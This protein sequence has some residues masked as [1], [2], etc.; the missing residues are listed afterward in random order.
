MKVLLF[1]NKQ[2]LP[3]AMKAKQIIDTFGI[4][5]IK[6]YTILVKECSVYSNT[7]LVDGFTWLVEQLNKKS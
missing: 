2:D 1:A 3:N 5:E 6:N 7:G 4:N